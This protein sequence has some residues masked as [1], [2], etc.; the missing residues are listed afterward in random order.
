MNT[1]MHTCVQVSG[2]YS[3]QIAKTLTRYVEELISID[4]YTQVDAHIYRTSSSTVCGY[5]TFRQSDK[6]E[7]HTHTYTYILQGFGHIQF[8]DTEI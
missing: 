2:T 5:R 7:I 3:L 4:I 8:A 6:Y 1:H